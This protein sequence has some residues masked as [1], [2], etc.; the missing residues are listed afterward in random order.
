M[1]YK[2]CTPE[3]LGKN[4]GRSPGGVGDMDQRDP[5]GFGPIFHGDQTNSK[6]Q[7]RTQSEIDQTNLSSIPRNET[8]RNQFPR[9]A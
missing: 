2:K 1:G 9:M 7:K 4:T 3:K 5:K 6:I 8:D